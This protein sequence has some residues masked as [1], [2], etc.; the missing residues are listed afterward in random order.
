MS[1][2]SKKKTAFRHVS[3]IVECLNLHRHGKPVA[4]YGSFATMG[5]AERDLMRVIP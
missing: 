4:D 2:K 5:G 1:I 3:A